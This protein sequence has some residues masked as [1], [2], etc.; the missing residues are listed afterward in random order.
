MNRLRRSIDDKEPCADRAPVRSFGV[1]ASARGE[2]SS[3]SAP[4]G[5]E[6]DGVDDSAVGGGGGGGDV[7]RLVDTAGDSL[8]PPGRSGDGGGG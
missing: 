2:K 4:P 5:D 7:G 6:G 1:S 3:V 8:E